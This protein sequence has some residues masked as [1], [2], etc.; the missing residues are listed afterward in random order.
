MAEKLHV[1][2]FGT[3][4][5]RDAHLRELME[6]API[7]KVHRSTSSVHLPGLVIR[8]MVYE[9]MYTLER[10]VGCR[11]DHFTLDEA[12]LPEVSSKFMNRFMAERVNR[13][14]SW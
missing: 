6:K 11:V 7:L 14:K 3:T 2:F 1:I 4:G 9:G 10:L 5:A 12:S 8:L 13:V